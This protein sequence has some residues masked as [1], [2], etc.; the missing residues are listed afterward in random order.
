MSL[1]EQIFHFLTRDTYICTYI[2]NCL[3]LLRLYYI[4]DYL[5]SNAKTQDLDKNL[6]HIYIAH[7]I[8]VFDHIRTRGVALV[9]TMRLIDNDCYR[10]CPASIETSST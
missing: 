7:E 10:E 1:L 9:I 2:K 4:A 6:I 5:C 3:H 8:D